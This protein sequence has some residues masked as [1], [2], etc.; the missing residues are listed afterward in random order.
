MSCWRFISPCEFAFREGFSGPDDGSRGFG[1]CGLVPA[2]GLPGRLVF[3]DGVAPLGVTGLDGAAAFV[4]TAPFAVSSP[5]LAVAATP[6]LP[7]FTD[8]N[9]ERFALAARSCCICSG[10]AEV[11]GARAAACSAGVGRAAVPPGPPL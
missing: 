7:R 10:L 11:C 9:C 3:S 4:E 5:G 2:G 1:G 6:G 8:A